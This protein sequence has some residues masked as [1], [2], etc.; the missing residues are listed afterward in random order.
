MSLIDAVPYAL[1]DSVALLS[2]SQN[3]PVRNHLIALSDS[4]GIDPRAC[5]PFN[6]ENTTAFNKVLPDGAKVPLQ[7]AI[8]PRTTYLPDLTVDDVILNGIEDAMI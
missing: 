6:G 5:G 3:P 4:P 7:H 2:R 1:E 8:A